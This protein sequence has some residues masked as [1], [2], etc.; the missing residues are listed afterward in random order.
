[1]VWQICI[2]GSNPSGRVIMNGI[3]SGSQIHFHLCINLINNWIFNLQMCKK[4]VVASQAQGS[5]HR[6]NFE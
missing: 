2:Y 1:M 6:Q 3:D 4:A 5:L